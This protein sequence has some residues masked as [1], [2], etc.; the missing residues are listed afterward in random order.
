MREIIKLKIT[1]P[2]RKS[3]KISSGMHTLEKDSAAS[4]NTKAAA[5]AGRGVV[6]A[7]SA[8]DDDR[9]APDALPPVFSTGAAGKSREN[10]STLQISN[11]FIGLSP[12]KH[13]YASYDT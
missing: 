5:G 13:D 2:E 8:E 9:P 11:R 6:K 3:T 1:H 4:A 10:E 12:G 7:S